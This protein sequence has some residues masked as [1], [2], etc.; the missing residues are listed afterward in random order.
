MHNSSIADSLYHVVSDDGI[1][2]KPP[3]GIPHT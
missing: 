2:G 3:V 1:A